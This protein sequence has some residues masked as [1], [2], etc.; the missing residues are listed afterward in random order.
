MRNLRVAVD[1]GGT[2]TDLVAYD[3]DTHE[4]TTVKTPSTPPGFIDG[5]MTRST[6][7]ASSPARSAS[8]STAR[9]SRTNAIIERTRRRDRARHH[10]GHARRAPRRARQPPRPLQLELGPVAAARPA[11]Q[12]PHRARAHRLRGQRGAPSSTRTTSRR[13]RP[14]VPRG[15]ASSPS[16]SAYLNSFMNPEHE[17]RTKAILARSSARTCSCARRRDPARD[18]RVRAHVDHR[19]QRLPRAGDRPLPATPLGCTRLRRRGARGRACS[20]PT[21]AAA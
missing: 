15:A 16:P 4:L 8:S 3:E 14:Q 10:G 11:P 6:R 20:S 18:P 2:F 9:R 19:R 7:P 5:V 13:R 17:A 21:R 1:I 12:R